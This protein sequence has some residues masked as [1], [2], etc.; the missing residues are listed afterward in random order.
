MELL[1]RLWS[2]GF[3][4]DEIDSHSGEVRELDRATA[5]LLAPTGRYVNLRLTKPG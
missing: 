1:E 4:I 3:Q 2:F 5:A